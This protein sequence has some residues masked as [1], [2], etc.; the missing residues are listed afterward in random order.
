MASFAALG[1]FQSFSFAQDEV[2]AILLQQCA[3][4]G[5]T[6]EKALVILD[7]MLRGGRR[8]KFHHTKMS[9][10]I[11]E[12]NT[13][14]TMIAW[15]RSGV[16]WCGV[17]GVND[18]MVHFTTLGAHT[19]QFYPWNCTKT[20]SGDCPQMPHTPDVCIF[21]C[22][23]NKDTWKSKAGQ[24]WTS[25]PNQVQTLFSKVDKSFD[26]PAPN[27]QLSNFC[28][29]S[30]RQQKIWHN[31]CVNCFAQVGGCECAIKDKP[32]SAWRNCFL[33]V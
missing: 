23:P 29:C 11:H 10:E 22:N 15:L 27:K 2:D 7:G 26:S 33:L 6:A 18:N 8:L 28:F 13:P 4:A 9:R 24:V 14:W 5:T 32:S 30:Q 20:Q 1:N 31:C 25:I 12:E 19:A 16:M 3:Q 21:S 17:V